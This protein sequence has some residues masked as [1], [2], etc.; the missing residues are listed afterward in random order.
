[1][2]LDMT[3]GRVVASAGEVRVEGGV[4]ADESPLFEQEVRG[5]RVPLA[6]AVGGVGVD[7]ELH[8]FAVVDHLTVPLNR[9]RPLE[10]DDRG[11]TVSEGTFE[12]A[13]SSQLHGVGRAADGELPWVGEGSLG[14]GEGDAAVLQRGEQ[15]GQ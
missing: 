14:G 1:A 10:V 12:V 11:P 3:L 8:G 13:H 9:I 6:G 2:E 5:Q 15:G 4:G 7:A